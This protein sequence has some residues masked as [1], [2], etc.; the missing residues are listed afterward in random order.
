MKIDE[1][2]LRIAAIEAFVYLYPASHSTIDT[3]WPRK[4]PKNNTRQRTRGALRGSSGSPRQRKIAIRPSTPPTRRKATTHNRGWPSSTCLTIT[5]ATAI[6]STALPPYNM[7]RRNC[8]GVRC[9]AARWRVTSSTPAD[10]STKPTPCSAVRRSDSN[11]ND[12]TI[13]NGLYRLPMIPMRAAPNV[14]SARKYK[15][16][17]TAMPRAPDMSVRMSANGGS[18][19][20][21]NPGSSTRVGTI[22]ASTMRFFSRFNCSGASVSPRRL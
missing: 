20:Q 22:S 21:E 17:A 5:I 3:Y 13:T 16:S 9:C 1:V 11:R 6:S 15:V 4:A 7:P 18:D 10:T 12:S 8:C 2:S 19:G 14:L